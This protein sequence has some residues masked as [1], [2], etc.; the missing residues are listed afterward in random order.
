MA[1]RIITDSASDVPAHFN[2]NISVVPLHIHIGAEEYLDGSTITHDEFYTRLINEDIFPQTSQPN[3]Y[4]FEAVIRP[5]IEAGDEAIIFTVSGELSGTYESALG[6]VDALGVSERVYV[7]DTRS[8]SLGECALISLTQNLIDA[9]MSFREITKR[10]QEIQP[11]LRVVAL[12][13]TL[14]YLKRGGRISKTQAALGGMLNIKPIITAREGRIE[15]AGKARGSK[16][17]SRALMDVI[18]KE[19]GIT[20]ELPVWVGYTGLNSEVMMPFFQTLTEKLSIPDNHIHKASA[21]AT[22]G[23]HGGAGCII[24]GYFAH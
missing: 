10:I 5:I 17:A 7:H 9:G 18:E 24:V 12:L 8:A 13:D 15:M 21:G 6:A 1:I 3:P 23:C 20:S 22:I 14:E 11:R 16:N 4:A 2:S 19:G